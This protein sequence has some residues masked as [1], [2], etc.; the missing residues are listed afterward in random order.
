M[1]CSFLIYCIRPFL[2]FS[3]YAEELLELLKG[4][5]SYEDVKKTLGKAVIE[6]HGKCDEIQREFLRHANKSG[7]LF[8]DMI[9]RLTKF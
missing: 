4:D 7:S 9:M 5:A 8:F 2:Y 1:R 6:L 3:E